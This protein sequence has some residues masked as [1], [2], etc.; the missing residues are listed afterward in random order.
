MSVQPSTN[1][2]RSRAL[3]DL[4][5]LGTV[6]SYNVTDQ[7]AFWTAVIGSKFVLSPPGK[8]LTTVLYCI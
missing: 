5:H 4:S 8:C 2:L 6:L 7:D 3:A 1:P